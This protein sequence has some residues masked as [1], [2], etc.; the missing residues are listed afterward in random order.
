MKKVTLNQI[1]KV[2]PCKEGWETLLKG[3][4]KTKPDDV[5]FDVFKIIETNNLDDCLWVLCEVLNLQKELRLFAYWNANQC[6]K[7][8]PNKEKQEYRKVINTVNMHA[9]GFVDDYARASAWYSAR[10]SENYEAYI[11]KAIEKLKEIVN[12]KL[13]AMYKG[14]NHF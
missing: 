12:G 9:Y 14:N 10:Y 2:R 5:E 7:Y 3:L 4:N 11:E 6:L 13:P 8:I 1:K